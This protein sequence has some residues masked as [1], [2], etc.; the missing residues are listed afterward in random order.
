MKT[1]RKNLLKTFTIFIASL[2][3]I[4][5]MSSIFVP[6]KS[7][8][9]AELVSQASQAEESVFIHSPTHSAINGSKL[10]FVDEFD[11]KFKVYDL[12]NKCFLTKT[13]SLENYKII[14]TAY[15]DNHF[16][17]L[18]ENE[19][20]T[21][22][23]AINLTNENLNIITVTT[24]ENFNNFDDINVSVFGEDSS[25]QYLVALSPKISQ[26]LPIV[27]LLNNNLEISK[28]VEITPIIDSTGMNLVKFIILKSNETNYYFV[29]VYE[30]KIY[31]S[32]CTISTIQS[33]AG[34]LNASFKP[35]PDTNIDVSA[36]KK[37][38]D[39]NL[40]EI[41]NQT[42]DEIQPAFVLTFSNTNNQQ[43]S[44]V[45]EYFI[46]ND[47]DSKTEFSL[48]SNIDSISS[49]VST[50]TNEII[51]ISGTYFI[52]TNSQSLIY[53][54][55]EFANDKYSVV[56]PNIV[57]NPKISVD[58]WTDS[59]FKYAYA[60][61]ETAILP[62]PW[63]DTIY[64][65][66]QENDHI[67][68]IGESKIEGESQPISGYYFCMFTTDERN[69]LGYIKTEDVSY[70]SNDID[71]NF[72]KY[73]YFKV[74]AETQVYSLPTF[75]T[76]YKIDIDTNASTSTFDSKK[77]GVI[78]D[79]T[80]VTL[81]NDIPI[82]SVKYTAN[83]R[84]FVKVKTS[85]IEG[86]ID[87]DRII[88][89]T[90]ST[91]FII[92]N[93]SIKTDNTKV[94]REDGSVI[95][96]LNKDYRVRINGTRNTKTGYTSISFNDEYGNEFTGYILT[97]SVKANSWTTLQILGSILIAINIG[98]LVLILIFKKRKI[99]TNGE[100]YKKEEKPNYKENVLKDN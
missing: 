54:E 55:I 96:T 80:I 24:T 3:L 75:F 9:T 64:H 1:F 35:F 6:N 53:R 46:D 70:L 15:A 59:N 38:I 28:Q 61:K 31:C 5:T 7:L 50:T 71:S 56:E 77:I 81:V 16:F 47:D 91:S 87:A 18:A 17:M 13:Q 95:T 45:Y 20:Q 43:S 36:E 19:S 72:K 68:I 32:S 79:N 83:G 21:K 26:T 76:D 23:F 58:Y 93:A 27:L 41:K 37:I 57:A 42:A 33:S 14:D 11:A 84:T 88:F 78:L 65:S 74:V 100:L 99:G 30:T 8:A 97:D 67:V 25:K 92:T 89:P 60:N 73:P 85:E 94:Y 51:S 4:L 40:L 49:F 69:Y 10:Y 29:N 66:I 12:E 48:L 86:Y 2:M 98:L 22:I 44:F 82:N 39:A 34:S 63:S 52:N 90:S 62:T